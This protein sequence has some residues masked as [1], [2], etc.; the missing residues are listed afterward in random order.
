M[1]SK[2]KIDYDEI[3]S[4]I[5]SN[6]SQIESKKFS[7]TMTNKS[8]NRFMLTLIILIILAVIF[9]LGMIAF[10]SD[11]NSVVSSLNNILNYSLFHSVSLLSKIYPL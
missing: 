9:I 5:N 1:K 11:G 4:K 8:W 6:H 7:R 10:K 3:I 2:D